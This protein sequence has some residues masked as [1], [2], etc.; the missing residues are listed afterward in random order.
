MDAADARAANQAQ[1]RQFIEGQSAS[2]LR[3][4]R[5]YVARAGLASGEVQV[6]AAADDLLNEVVVEALDHAE[7][8]DP[9]GVP[10]AW[11]LGIAANLLRRRQADLAK[12]S[13][14]EPLARDLAAPY[15]NPISDDDLFD[16]FAGLAPGG[17]DPAAALESDAAVASLLARVSEDDR[18]VL[19]LALIHELDGQSLA[20]ALGVR[21][22]A[23]RVRLHRALN[24]LREAVGPREGWD[25][26]AQ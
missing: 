15:D 19:R 10:V 17:E 26:S 20:R 9:S 22:G 3:T 4:L 6:R 1:L 12:R 7:R 18:R 24:R 14:R 2:L 8:F 11:L 5:L 25:G 16:R 21:P 23:A 13:R